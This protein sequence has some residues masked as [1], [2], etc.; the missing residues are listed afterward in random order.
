MDLLK[1][2]ILC[3]PLVHPA[4]TLRVIEVESHGNPYAVR[5]NTTRRSFGLNTEQQAQWLAE[6][7]IRAGHRVDLG[8]MQINYDVWLKPTRVSLK[9]ALD[10]CINIR[11]G[12]TILSANYARALRRFSRTADPLS[13]ALS[14][15][16]S[17]AEESALSYAQRVLSSS[18]TRSRSR[19]APAIP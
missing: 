18:T 10:P 16:N 1:L 3:G 12:T 8:L 17:G 7:L 5:D 2:A 9:A 11:L 13:R 6:L 4:T 19:P 15:Y 14:V